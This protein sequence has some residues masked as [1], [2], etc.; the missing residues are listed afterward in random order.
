[1]DYG[2]MILDDMAVTDKAVNYIYRIKDNTVYESYKASQQELKQT[3]RASLQQSITSMASS[4]VTFG[5]ATVAWNGYKFTT[6]KSM[7]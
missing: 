7:G 4:I 1:M 6:T 3:L 2:I 5:F